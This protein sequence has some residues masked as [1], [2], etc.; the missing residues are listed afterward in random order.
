MAELNVTEL[1]FD[2]IKQNLQTFLAGQAEFQDYNFDGAG[3]SILLDIL[4]YNTHYNAISAHFLAN[5]MFIDSA[6]KRNSVVSIAKTMGY[7]P[8][9]RRSA[10]AT[11]A[12]TIKPGSSYTSAQYTLSRDTVVKGAYGSTTYNFYPKEDYFA[13]LTKNTLNQ[14]V[15]EFSSVDFIEGTRVQN[16]FIVDQSNLSGPFVLPNQN[17]DTTTIRVRV[18][19]SS[20]QFAITTF[21]QYEDIL[22]VNST[23]NAF[24][25]EEGPAG[26]HEVR[27]GDDIIGK[28]LAVGN[29]VIIDYI[30]SG[31]SRGNSIS[32]FNI[33]AT[34][35]ASGEVK[36]ISTQDAASG[37]SEKQGIDSIRVLA[38][39]YN[40]TK[41]RAVTS[42]DYN[43][44]IQSR[45]SNI[46]SITIWGGEENDPPIYGKIFVSIDPL[47]GSVITQADKDTIVREIIKPRSVVTTQVE[48]VDPE[49][50]YIGLDVSVDYTK[51]TTTFTSSTISSE[52]LQVINNYFDTGLN[53][54]E[55]N[56]YFSKLS[57]LINGTT[58][59][60]FS[61]SMS[62]TVHKRL[63]IFEGSDNTFN[64]KFNVAATEGSFRS[65]NF[66]TTLA[67]QSFSVYLT[68]DGAGTLVV[69]KVSDDS[70]LITNVGT[71]SYTDGS[72]AIPS[73]L[74]DSLASNLTEIRFYLTP[75]GNSP[76][77]LVAGVISQ[78]PF[79]TGPA[80]PIYSKNT[81][82][83]LDTSSSDY[84]ANIPTGITVS[85]IPNG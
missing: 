15:F 54:L 65:T 70:I 42:A 47:P 68:D 56:F 79:S 12:M 1:D 62:V 10:V 19:T 24:F 40:A 71:I 18:Q 8:T 7:T 63:N 33:P 83:R 66:N 41:N 6:L 16:T 20:T 81:V 58:S 22:N 29:I 76:N 82:I 55:K 53:K 69:K 44:L 4:A 21:T 50:I 75:S 80:F 73:L 77:I 9:S 84:D 32:S 17:V 31:G 48:F 78:Q 26:L 25:V 3:L 28:Q 74:I 13:T 39:K 27:F 51:T 14:D 85:A 36:N 34:L 45:F 23:T 52:V 2:L 30:V 60:I 35:T 5:E 64:V 46:N 67:N 49:A 37:G 59:S 57:A 43:S 61:N 11:V 72:I 38:P